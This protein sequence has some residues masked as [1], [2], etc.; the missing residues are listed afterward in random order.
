MAGMKTR[1][2][3]VLGFVILG[4]LGLGGAGIP[5]EAAEAGASLIGTAKWE[6]EIQAFEATDRTTPPPERPILFLGS[7]SIRM[8]K[9]L[10]EDF[11]RQP[12]LNRGFGGSQIIDSTY[13][14]DRIATP[15]R[16]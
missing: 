3:H 12:V 4:W 8:W 1:Y 2:R 6:A 16:P 13:L 14:A 10:A 9:T 15:Y 7:S 11:P 5:V